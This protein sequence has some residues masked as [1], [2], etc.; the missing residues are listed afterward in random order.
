MASTKFEVSM[1]IFKFQGEPDAEITNQKF[2]CVCGRSIP[3]LTWN[4]AKRCYTA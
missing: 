4:P 1:E 3:K 2:S